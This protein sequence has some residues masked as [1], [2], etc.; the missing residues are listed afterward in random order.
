MRVSKKHVCQAFGKAAKT[1]N[2]AA[3]VQS[4]ILKRLLSRLSL[5]QPES[6]MLLDL[7][8]GTGLA[9]SAIQEMYGCSAY[10][11]LDMANP[12][13][14]YACREDN[15]KL[16]YKAVCADMEILP[17]KNDVVETIFSASS[18]QW[19]NDIQATFQECLRVLKTEGLI[20]YSTFGPDTLK[21]IQ[22]CF[23]KVDDHQHVK[24][25]I[26]MHDLGDILLSAGF[27]SPVMESEIITVE[28]SD[29]WQLFRDLKA[30]GATNHL[31][32]R[33][34]GLFG[35][36]RMQ[37]VLEEYKKFQLPN[38]KYPASYEVIYGHGRKLTKLA[39]HDDP[40]QWQPVRF[41]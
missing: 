35:K 26:D 30:T 31:Q 34:R 37:S 33:S 5:L 29:P 38:G 1:Y 32:D 20:L 18:L 4:E 27:A 13:L 25:F 7:G 8:S 15:K 16:L 14:Q 11:A 12:M 21:E 3:V 40:Q 9:R 10:I 41:K 6:E 28:Y 36:E 22:H 2:E 19:C 24:T 23:R 39:T 17:F